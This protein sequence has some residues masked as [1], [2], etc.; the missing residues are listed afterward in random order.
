[1]DINKRR[2][3]EKYIIEKMIKIYCHGNKHTSNGLCIDCQNLLEYASLRI[4]KC[5]FMHN[6]TFCSSCKVH[7][8]K[9]DMRQNIKMVMRYAGPRMIFHHPILL[10]KHII[11]EKRS[12][13]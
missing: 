9:T 6:K 3:H 8:Y 1:M 7:C 2:N 5:P 10:I 4:D 11:E 13:K 12:N